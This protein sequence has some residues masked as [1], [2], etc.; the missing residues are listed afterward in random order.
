MGIVHSP[1]LDIFFSPPTWKRG[2]HKHDVFLAIWLNNLER[3]R[4]WTPNWGA[5]REYWFCHLENFWLEV[6]LPASS[7]SKLGLG[8]FKL[9][10]VFAEDHLLWTPLP[11]ILPPHALVLPPLARHPCVERC[12]SCLRHLLP[13]PCKPNS[14]PNIPT[15]IRTRKILK[16]PASASGKPTCTPSCQHDHCTSPKITSPLHHSQNP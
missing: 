13:N 3:N 7:F 14:K 1:L 12:Q 5:W 16:H 2:K 6:E 8:T 15:E 11:L 4:Y 10:S 9:A